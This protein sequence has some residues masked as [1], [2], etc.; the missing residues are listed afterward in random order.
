[1]THKGSESYHITLRLFLF[2]ISQIIISVEN[3]TCL[4]YTSD[5]ADE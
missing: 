1:M 2:C 3:H 5:A 4:L